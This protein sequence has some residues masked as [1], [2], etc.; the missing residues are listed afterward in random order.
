ELL[1]RVQAILRRSEGRA[2]IANQKE[3]DEARRVQQRLMPTDIP[4]VRGLQ[5]AGSWIPARIAGGDYFDVLKLDDDTV[6]VC[7]ADVSGK[8]MPAAMLMSN[9]QAAVKTCASEGL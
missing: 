5:I 3:L 2:D 6:A 9:L 8:G 1:G 7:V 4:Q